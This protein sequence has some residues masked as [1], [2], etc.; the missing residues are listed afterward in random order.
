[1]SNT[2]PFTEAHAIARLD[3]SLNFR[4][5]LS[6]EQREQLSL[7]LETHL[8]QFERAAADTDDEEDGDESAI[9]FNRVGE[10]DEVT[11]SVHIHGN[12]VHVV[13]SDYRGWSFSRD[14]ALGYLQPVLASLRDG[15]LALSSV[16][17]TY[18]DV[19]FNDVPDS[20]HA[21]DV[22]KTGSQF[23]A[24][25]IFSSGQRWR[26][27]LAW[28]NAEPENASLITNATLKI[29]AFSLSE[30][31]SPLHCTAIVHSQSLRWRD[32]SLFA[33]PADEDVIGAWDNARVANRAL[34]TELITDDMLERVGLKEG[35]K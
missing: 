21:G 2:R 9:V 17:L 15:R 30:D 22:L 6:D 23:V 31:D 25:K 7:A 4:S 24:P 20:Y 8:N 5:E 28:S 13:W 19:F 1:M 27:W 33:N 10:D 11:E 32:D 12:Y 14:G 3:F 16:G 35:S 29:D 18:H 34:I 26:H